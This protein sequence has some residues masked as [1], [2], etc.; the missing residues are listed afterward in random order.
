MCASN[1]PGGGSLLGLATG[2]PGLGFAGLAPTAFAIANR[3]SN[4]KSAPKPGANGGMTAPTMP[5]PQ[6]MK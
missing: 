1:L 3:N 5:T 2:K 6:A 4:R